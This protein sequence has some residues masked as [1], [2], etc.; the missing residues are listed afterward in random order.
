MFFVLFFPTT[1]IGAVVAVVHVR[2]KKKKGTSCV[3]ADPTPEVHYRS[4][5]K[6]R[7][8]HSLHTTLKKWAERLLEYS[9]TA[10]AHTVHRDVTLVVDDCCEFMEERPA[11]SLNVYYGK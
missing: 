3:T 11:A 5:W 2:S 4:L 10:Y 8:P 9:I 6:L 1:A 7:P